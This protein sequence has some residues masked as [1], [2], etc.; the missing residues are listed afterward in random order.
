MPQ[1]S[2]MDGFLFLIHNKLSAGSRRPRD[3]KFGFQVGIRYQ[4]CRW[5]L[6][7]F[8]FKEP[9]FILL[10]AK[11]QIT[12]TKKAYLQFLQYFL[13]DVR[14]ITFTIQQSIW[15]YSQRK[16]KL[17]YMTMFIIYQRALTGV[18]ILYLYFKVKYAKLCITLSRH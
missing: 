5:N 6:F 13:I 8:Y 15:V 2:T 11:N 17:T 10:M 4:R 16:I 12:T 18:H 1:M 14:R 7:L 3:L 9:N